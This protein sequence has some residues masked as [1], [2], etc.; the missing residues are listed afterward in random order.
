MLNLY[1]MRAAGTLPR[2]SRVYIESQRL[3]KRI[4]NEMGNFNRGYASH[5]EGKWLQAG[6]TLCSAFAFTLF[7]SVVSPCSRFHGLQTALA[8]IREC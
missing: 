5:L 6:I 4:K 7:G 3:T 8:M 2:A 1:L